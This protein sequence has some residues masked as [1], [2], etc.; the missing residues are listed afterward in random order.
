[1]IWEPLR[2]DYFQ[3][4]APFLDRFLKNVFD[5][6]NST[7]TKALQRSIQKRSIAFKGVQAV[8][9]Y[10]VHATLQDR[11]RPEITY[12]NTVKLVAVEGLDAIFFEQNVTIDVRTINECMW[13]EFAPS[14]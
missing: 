5:H 3:L 14:A 11:L 2:V 12:S 10:D 7:R 1:M 8:I 4:I 13:E 9:N 6:V